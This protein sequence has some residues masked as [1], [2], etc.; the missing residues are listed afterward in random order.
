M[1]RVVRELVAIAVWVSVFVQLFV[2]DIDVLAVDTIAPQYL[3]LLQY[4]FLA[5]FGIVAIL[6]LALGTPRFRASIAYVLFYPIVVLCWKL[7]RL[8]FRNWAA[9]LVFA[10]A[11]HSTITTFRARFISA[12]FGVL[13]MLVVLASKNQGLLIGAMTIMLIILVD[14]F[15]R[16]FYAA[17]QT[18]T[19]FVD[20]GNF[21]RAAGE[22]V[23]Q[24]TVSVDLEKVAKL[25]PKSEEYKAKRFEVL[26]TLF[27]FSLLYEF[28]AVKANEMLKRR[29]IDLYYVSSLLATIATSVF[30]FGLEYLALEKVQPGSFSTSGEP[31]FWNFLALS[32]NRLLATDYGFV[33]PVSGWAQILYN[34]ELV[35][36]LFILVIMVFVLTTIVRERYRDDMDEAVGMLR[37]QSGK[38]E[39]LLEKEF[40]LSLDQAESSLL[41]EK[42]DHYRGMIELFRGKEDVGA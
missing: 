13:S 40:Q 24:R 4:R 35:A 9:F 21:F 1:A 42:P 32:F 19:V 8:V 11:I 2:Y 14:H 5:L 34:V 16:R 37:E 36:S 25:D 33:L 28:L 12:G 27:L 30:V 10:P 29:S 17:F 15:R 38:V 18:K 6:W 39:E 7:P 31:S 26:G 3:Y 41:A 20:L 22:S 23:R